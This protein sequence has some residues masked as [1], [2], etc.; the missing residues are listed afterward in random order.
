MKRLLA[1]TAIALGAALT[2]PVMAQQTPTSPQSAT[3]G[4]PP[5]PEGPKNAKSGS[6]SGSAVTNDT[7]HSG[8]TGSG[9][10]NKDKT[11]GARHKKPREQGAAATASP[12]A[13]SGPKGDSP[14]PAPGTTK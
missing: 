11:T 10:M 14:D 9:T 6:M 1:T 5:T 2:L 4:T 8:A 12:T 3:P 13:P 7:T